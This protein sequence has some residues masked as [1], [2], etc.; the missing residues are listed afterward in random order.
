[1]KKIFM[2]CILLVGLNVVGNICCAASDI[3]GRIIRGNPS[4]PVTIIE[5]TDFQC[6]YCADGAKML[7]DIME[8]FENKVNLII[9][10]SPLVSIHPMALPTATYFEAIAMQNPDSA[11][12]F[13][14]QIFTNQTQLKNGEKWLI[15]ISSE[16]GVDTARLA[17]DVKSKGVLLRI[18]ADLAKSRQANFGGVPVFVIGDTILLGTQEQEKFISAINIALGK[19]KQ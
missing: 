9:V 10:H 1:M 17:E 19:K 5:Y 14:D 4:A 8:K 2:L 18:A 7:K 13:Y 3:D 6:P 11:W 16:I 15:K 12:N